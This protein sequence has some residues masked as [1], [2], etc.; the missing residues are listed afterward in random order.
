MKFYELHFHSQKMSYNNSFYILL[1]FE[2]I[3]HD[4][5][6]VQHLV[7]YV[8]NDATT[9]EMRDLCSSFQLISR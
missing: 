5:L 8:P 1:S 7:F 2:T 3:Q 6:V 9:H 4:L